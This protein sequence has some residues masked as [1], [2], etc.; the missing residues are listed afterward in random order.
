MEAYVN[1]LRRAIFQM[2]QRNAP[3]I[4]PHLLYL[5]SPKE[6]QAKGA[7]SSFFSVVS[8]SLGILGVVIR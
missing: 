3:S 6:L 2:H 4:H 1:L 7:E 8:K 5:L